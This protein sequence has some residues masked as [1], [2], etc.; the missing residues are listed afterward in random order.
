[1]TQKGVELLL[2]VLA[3]LPGAAF[4]LATDKDQPVH[5]EADRGELDDAK[6]VTTYE[7]RVVVTQGTIKITGDRVVIHY[8]KNR[9]VDR[10]EAFGRPATYEQRPDGEK[11]PVRAKALRMDYQVKAGVV[12]LYD[13]AS[14]IQSG[15]SLFGS[16]ITYDTVNERVKASRAGSG[17]DRV[18]VI[19][20]P[21]AKENG[22]T[23]PP[24]APPAKTAPGKGPAR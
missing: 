11:E 8:D 7:G 18:R 5:I 19:L 24:T 10:A 1:M 13:D 2:I 17:D 6:G 3:T 22:K 14:V 23:E 20:T 15:N 16:R 12:D 9:E 21:K 4:A